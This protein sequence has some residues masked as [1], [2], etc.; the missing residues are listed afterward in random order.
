[1]IVNEE[2]RDYMHSKY[3]ANE[4]I[5]RFGILV[6]EDSEETIVEVYLK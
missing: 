3:G 6:N 5:I 2:I 1:M 4:E